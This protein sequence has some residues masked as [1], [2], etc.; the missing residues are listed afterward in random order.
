MKYT[1]VC[2]YNA[3]FIIIEVMFCTSQAALIE[4][5]RVQEKPLAK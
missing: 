3:I 5:R 4:E 2:I 1:I